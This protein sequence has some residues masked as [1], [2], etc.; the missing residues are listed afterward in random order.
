MAL[1]FLDTS[2]FV[3]AYLEDEEGHDDALALLVAGGRLVASDLLGVEA[4]R[5]IRGAE[6]VGRITRQ[7]A[8]EVLSEMESDTSSEGIVDLIPLDGPATVAR[9]RELVFD[10]PVRTL[11]ALHLAVAE[12]EGRRLAQPDEDLVFT[13]FDARQRETARALGFTVW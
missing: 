10:H 6:R 2:V 4:V 7:A 1:S 5:A 13:T 11:D 8:T 9:A 3:R 12:R